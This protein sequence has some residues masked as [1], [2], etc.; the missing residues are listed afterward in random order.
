MRSAGLRL[1]PAHVDI[2]YLLISKKAEDHEDILANFNKG[3]AEIKSD[4]TLKGI[5]SKHG[6]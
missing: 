4:C 1:T 3:L 6:F 2:Q 5:M